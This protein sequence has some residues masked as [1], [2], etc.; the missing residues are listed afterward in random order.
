MHGARAVPGGDAR[1]DAGAE[2]WNILRRRSADSLRIDAHAV[3][4]FYGRRKLRPVLRIR[5]E[6]VHVPA[7]ARERRQ[8]AAHMSPHIQH[9]AR[10]A[11][12]VQHF[13]HEPAFVE[14]KLFRSR[15]FD[16]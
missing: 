1:A 9:H 3:D 8:R 5:F 12:R 13:V 4:I 6:R 11:A 16:F 2:K 10:T 7:G 14:L 15:A